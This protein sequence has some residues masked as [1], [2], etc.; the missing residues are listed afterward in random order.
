MPQDD[1]SQT[2]ANSVERRRREDLVHNRWKTQATGAID[3][4]G[5]FALRGFFGDWGGIIG[6]LIGMAVSLTASAEVFRRGIRPRPHRP[7]RAHAGNDTAGANCRFAI[8]PV[9]PLGRL[10]Q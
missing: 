4:D 10:S 6:G 3:A 9:S 7:D 2:E 5:R 8:K 1:G